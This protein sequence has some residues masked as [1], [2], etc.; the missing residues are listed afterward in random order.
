MK[1]VGRYV[2]ARKCLDYSYHKLYSSERQLFQDTII[3]STLE[4]AQT[5]ESLEQKKK[6]F[7][8]AG[9]MGSGKTHC[10]KRY[11]GNDYDRYVIADIDKIK[12]CLPERQKLLQS[13]PDN[14]GKLLHPEASTIHELIYRTAV[15]QGKNVIIDTS[16]RNGEFFKDLY[17][18]N[19][20]VLDSRYEITIVHVTASFETCMRRAE[21][22]AKVTGR[23]VPR[24][25]IQ[26]S[27]RECPKSIELLRP[28]VNQIVV[29]D[30]D[31][32]D[33]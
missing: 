16:L 18:N 11:L 29:I 21:Y 31:K 2:Q 24:E 17:L 13:D 30:N 12:L 9:A 23:R 22:R 7:L 25:S 19:K 33:V 28:F 26:T 32:D 15:K 1:F 14:V 5:C 10:I 20:D 27:L 8:T 3:A 4:K 6:L